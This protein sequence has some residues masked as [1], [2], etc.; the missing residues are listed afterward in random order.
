MDHHF[1]QEIGIAIITATIMGLLIYRLKQ[2]VILGYFLAGAL[3]GPAIGLKLVTDPD[4]I[5]VISEIG[6]IL[7]LFVIGLEINFKKILAAGKQLFV[8]GIG[9]FFLCTLIGIGFFLLLGF[10]AGMETLYLAIFCAISSTAIVVKMLYDKFELDT[11]PGRMTLGI[12]IFQDIWAILILAFQP[13]FTD[14][15]LIL[16]VISLVE[17]TILLAVGYLLSRYVL[18]YIYN[19]IAKTPELVVAVSIGWCATMAGLADV[20]GL[21]KEMGGLIA[22]VAISNFPYSMHVTAK[23]LPLRDFFLI[24]FFIS[25]GMVVPLPTVSMVALALGIVLFVI[26]SRFLTIYPLLSLSGSG[27]RTSFIASL[28]L[29]QISEFSLVI[30]ALGLAYGHISAPINSLIIYA[31][32]FAAILSSYMIKYNHELYLLFNKFMDRF[33]TH[34]K[35][36]DREELGEAGAYPIVLLGFHRGAEA[37]I[38]YVSQNKREFLPKILVVDFNP[39]VLKKLHEQHVHAV[40]GDISSLDTLTHAHIE[41]ARIIISSIPDMMLKGTNNLWL[42]H[43]CRQLAPEAALVATA[44]TQEQAEELSMAGAHKVM[45]PYYLVGEALSEYVLEQEE[46][47]E[48]VHG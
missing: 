34:G 3:V 13:N 40:F 43:T 47:L 15:Q 7:L 42:V 24:L 25:L 22:G 6:L 10:G 46:L 8:A 17:T 2:P 37:F 18:G 20:M 12:L 41:H 16:L 30:A 21:S 48:A 26:V 23:I 36:G 44:E 19:M 28:N 5:Q 4:N 35:G 38:D 9:Q 11:L 31:M 29:S 1:L 33:I 45:L 32:A 39:E 27:R 14:P